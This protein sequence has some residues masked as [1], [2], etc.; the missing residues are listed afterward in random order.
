[1]AESETGIYRMAALTRASVRKSCDL[2][3]SLHQDEEELAGNSRSWID[4]PVLGATLGLGEP[5][6]DPVL[7]PPLGLGDPP[8]GPAAVTP[9]PEDGGT[10]LEQDG[11]TATPSSKSGSCCRWCAEEGLTGVLTLT[12]L[13]FILGYLVILFLFHE[14]SLVASIVD[15]EDALEYL[16][17]T[18]LV[19][20]F[21][22]FLLVVLILRLV[23]QVTLLTCRRRVLR[24]RVRKYMN[25]LQKGV[26]KDRQQSRRRSTAVFRGASYAS[27]WL[28]RV[29]KWHSR[30]CG[31]TGPYWA[32]W[33]YFM[34]TYELVLQTL[35][36]LSEASSGIQRGFLQFHAIVIAVNSF[37]IIVLTRPLSS[38]LIK[39]SLVYDSICDCCYG[40]ALFFFV[41]ITEAFFGV[42]TKDWENRFCGDTLNGYSGESC[43]DLAAYS[44]IAKVKE[45]FYGG[46]SPGPILLK[47]LT[48]LVPLWNAIG[49]TKYIVL[50]RHVERA[51]ELERQAME[52]GTA[53]TPTRTSVRLRRDASFFSKAPSQRQIERA[54]RVPWYL[55]LLNIVCAVSV[56][57]FVSIRLEQLE[58]PADDHFWKSAC[59]AQSWPIF[60][61][62]PAVCACHTLLPRPGPT[63][64]GCGSKLGAA[65]LKDYLE[66]P[67][68]AEYLQTLMMPGCQLNQSTL[69]IV[70]S[71]LTNLRILNIN[72][73]TSAALDV[74][75]TYELSPDFGRLSHLHYLRATESSLVGKPELG[76]LSSLRDV[77]FESN[78]SA[79]T[80]VPKRKQG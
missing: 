73:L 80:A 61:A 23:R 25:A 43:S 13:T 63:F 42:L 60:S 70:S 66:H 30:Y 59:A 53:S 58:C 36:L 76:K 33:T 79:T 47:L 64:P 7:G 75:A 39:F 49:R 24:R 38:R 15:E 62:E 3:I 2:D 11:P 50:T 48:R 4:N 28:F 67:T 68:A 6:E 19:Q 20:V 41:V 72:S 32:A 17:V 69:T 22:G 55:A 9:E 21:L 40:M 1:M 37:S 57:L 46:D 65:T 34:E 14:T 52:S 12:Y 44:L 71:Q 31:A 56:C 18:T 16:G 35:A 10:Q 45:G 26:R 51:R 27:A 5:P 74:G 77:K 54:W 8:P 78:V 29:Y